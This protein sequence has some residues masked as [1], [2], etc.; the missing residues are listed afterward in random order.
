MATLT[1]HLGSQSSI[2]VFDAPQPLSSVLIK[3][4]LAEA[5]P[6]GG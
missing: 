1:V 6:C 4:G 2:I 5:H 3:A